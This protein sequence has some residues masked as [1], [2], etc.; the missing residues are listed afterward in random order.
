M[1]WRKMMIQREL[2]VRRFMKRRGNVEN[3]E[4]FT[5]AYS[6]LR[7]L[8]DI[9]QTQCHGCSSTSRRTLGC[10]WICN[11][12]GSLCDHASWRQD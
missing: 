9:S 1:T 3:S 10:C 8:Q 11:F 6:V 2:K 7:R 12:H 5:G 4:E